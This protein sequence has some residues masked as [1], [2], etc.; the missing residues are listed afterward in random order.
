MFLWTGVDY[1]G[2]ADRAGWPNI[3]NPAGLLDRAGALK[4]VGMQRASWWAEQPVLHVVRN[5]APAA[6]PPSNDGAGPA[7]ALPTMIAVAT[8]QPKAALFDD[9]TPADLKPHPET[10]EVYSN[11]ANVEVSLNGRSLDAKPLP[12]D[13]SP[14]QWNVSFAPG[15]VIATCR[16]TGVKLQDTLRTAGAP[17]RLELATE[18]NTVGS[19]FDDLA[20]VR[21]RVID[22]EG[23][24]VPSATNAITFAVSGAGSFVASDSGAPTDHTPF[25]SPTRQAFSGK[26]TALVRGAGSTGVLT[27]NATAPGLK[28]ATI[29]LKVSR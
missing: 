20:F 5:A 2:E 25:P 12:A 10:I 26:A 8:P 21:A 23:V 29:T 28:P 1:L 27:V 9:W 16:D 19:A 15:E 4:I 22:A 3:D 6:P 17:V 11:C 13:A 18:D 14:R 24:V 7:P